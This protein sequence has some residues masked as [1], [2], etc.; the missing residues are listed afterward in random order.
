MNC[1]HAKYPNLIDQIYYNY[2]RRNLIEVRQESKILT[3]EEA[4]LLKHALWLCSNLFT[5]RAD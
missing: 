2:I 5:T 3:T 1:V 4:D